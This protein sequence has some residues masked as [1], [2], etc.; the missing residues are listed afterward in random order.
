MNRKKVFPAH[1]IMLNG[2]GI[3]ECILGKEPLTRIHQIIY[4]SG[5]NYSSKNNLSPISLDQSLI[6]LY[7]SSK[8]TKEVVIEYSRN[9][10]DIEKELFFE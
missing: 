9:P 2:P 1:E 6:R 10:N 7:N 5:K 4:E 3:K 8:I